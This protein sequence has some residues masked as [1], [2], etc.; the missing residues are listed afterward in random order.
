MPSDKSLLKIAEI[1]GKEKC[2]SLYSGNGFLE[3]LL[4]GLN[5]DVIAT[6]I[7]PPLCTF[8]KVE[9]L[10]ATGALFVYN[11]I[12]TFLLSWVPCCDSYDRRVIITDVI[13]NVPDA[14]LIYIGEENGCTGSYPSDDLWIRVS[15]FIRHIF[16]C[17]HDIVQIFKRKIV[18]MT[19]YETAIEDLRCLYD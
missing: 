3:Y 14:T 15:L 6:D 7:D 18:I 9:K 11:K 17:V 2:L 19:Y 8:T 12:T 16:H 5:C 10:S 1:I 13:S 4:Q